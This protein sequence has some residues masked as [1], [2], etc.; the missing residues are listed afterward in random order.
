MTRVAI[1][2]GNPR[3]AP[4]YADAVRDAGA[5]PV[6]ISA[7]A[8]V[9]SLAG[10]AGLM[11]AGGSDINPRVYGQEPAERT[12]PPDDARDGLELSL[13]AEAL[14]RDLPVLAICRGMQL[15][16]VAH[17]GGTLFQHIEG[18]E[19]R[20]ADPSEPAHTV[21]IEPGTALAAIVAESE[22]PVNSRHHQAV[23]RVGEG[24]IVSARAADGIVE[25]VERPDKRFALAVQWHPEDQRRFASHRRLLQAFVNASH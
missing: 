10:F 3:K 11:L 1:S 4:P 8:G 15:F 6:L 21:T 23:D 9:R 13:V 18:H 12:H 5:E 24:L 17:A 22:L 25:A 14:E 16:N 7:A 19:V 20:P 2:Y